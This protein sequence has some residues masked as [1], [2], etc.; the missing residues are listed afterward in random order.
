MISLLLSLPPL[1]VAVSVMGNVPLSVG[2]PLMTGEVK[3][4]QAGKPVTVSVI[5]SVPLA[6]A[7]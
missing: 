6:R 4:A 2:V 1:L 3:L 5:G 7:V